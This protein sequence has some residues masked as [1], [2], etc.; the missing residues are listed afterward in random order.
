MPTIIENTQQINALNEIETALAVI[1]AINT[2][3]SA[4][5]G[6][7]SI[8]YKPE[9]GRKVQVDVPD[10]SRGKAIG[11]L[12]ST[13]DRLVKE[14]KSKASKFRINLDDADLACMG[15]AQ[16]VDQVAMEDGADGQET[17]ETGPVA[18]PESSDANSNMDLDGD[19]GSNADSGSLFG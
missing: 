6:T 5:D 13:K 17:M 1:K 18:A 16:P 11:I 12:N 15:E 4:T 14:V 19:G 2:I 9:K 10:V 8:L 7:I 3:V